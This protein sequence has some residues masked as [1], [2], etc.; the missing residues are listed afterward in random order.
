MQL[1]VTHPSIITIS[2]RNLESNSVQYLSYRF[3]HT[4]AQAHVTHSGLNAKLFS[5]FNIIML[6]LKLMNELLLC[7]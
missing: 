6:L 5:L 4:Q 1:H 3:I 2:A 7:I